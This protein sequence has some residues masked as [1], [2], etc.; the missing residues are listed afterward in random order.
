MD[1]ATMERIHQELDP[2]AAMLAA[3]IVIVRDLW[4]AS[5]VE[6]I[7]TISLDDIIALCKTGEGGP[8]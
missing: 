1:D 7:R 3:N 5:D 8:L 4:N 2:G 6:D